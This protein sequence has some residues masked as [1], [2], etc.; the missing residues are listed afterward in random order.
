MTG[1]MSRP[2]LEDAL[3]VSQSPKRQLPTVGVIAAILCAYVLLGAFGVISRWLMWAGGA[4]FGAVLL[5]GLYGALRGRGAPWELRLDPDGVTVRGHMTRPWSDFTEVRVTGM[6][7]SWFFFV[8]LGYRVV[9]FIGRPGLELPTLP[10]A[11]FFGRAAGSARLRQRWYG[12]Q[13]LLMPY[14]FDAST[15]VIVD[16]VK[17]YSDVPVHRF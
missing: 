10:S 1:L 9:A 7:P 2:E 4:V 13:L 16:A 8:S 14:A 11:Q 5:I 6:R 3:L 17:R 12:S 15:E